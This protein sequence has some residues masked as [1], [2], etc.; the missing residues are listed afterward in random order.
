MSSGNPPLHTGIRNFIFDLD[1]TIGNTL[2]LCIRA[3][4]EAI[5]PLIGRHLTDAEIVAHFGPSEEG[6]IEA[7]AP[8]RFDEAL[9]GYLAW[10]R[11]HHAEYTTQPFAGITELLR[12][13]NDRGAFVGM[14][15]GKGWKSA[16][17]T[18]DVYGI[19]H[20][21][22]CVKTGSSE[23]VVKARRIGE[24]LAEHGGAKSSYLYIGDSTKDVDSCREA[25]IRI[26]AAGWAETTDV[27][28]LE[29]KHPDYLFTSVADFRAF[30]EK[31][32]GS[33]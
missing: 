31:E 7:L 12:Y 14:V 15:T 16:E 21:F 5:E 29:A 32:L 22:R 19:K 6:L 25:G 2:P 4:R 26:A 11:A 10:Y 20:L 13:L 23:G 33:N 30:A 24:I 28:A 17:I 3:F 9:N 1:G 18:L 8:K 27:A